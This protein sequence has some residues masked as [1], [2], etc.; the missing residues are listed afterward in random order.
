MERREKSA[1]KSMIRSIVENNLAK[2]G[3]EEPS[4]L[5]ERCCRRTK[6]ERIDSIFDVSRKGDPIG[7]GHTQVVY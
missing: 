3:P 5:R 7:W 6:R 1:R 2:R 4:L